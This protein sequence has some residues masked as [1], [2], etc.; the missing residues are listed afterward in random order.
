MFRYLFYFLLIK[1]SLQCAQFQG[2]SDP[3]QGKEKSNAPYSKEN[4]SKSKIFDPLVNV[5]PTPQTLNLSSQQQEKEISVNIDKKLYENFA[6]LTDY[7][8]TLSKIQAE[9]QE[10]LLGSDDP[11]NQEGANLE[12]E[13]EERSQNLIRAQKK[14]EQEFIGPQNLSLRTIHGSSGYEMHKENA[15]ITEEELKHDLRGIAAYDPSNN[16]IIITFHGSRNGA[17][18]EVNLDGILVPAKEIGLDFEGHPQMRVHRGFGIVVHRLFHS[19]CTTIEE[20]KKEIGD[21]KWERLEIYFTGHSQGAAISGLASLY[22]ANKKGKELFGED[23]NN[24]K[25]HRIKTYG[26]S[27][28]RFMEKDHIEAIE[29]EYGRHNYIRQNVHGDIVPLLGFSDIQDF[30]EKITG[31]LPLIWQQIC[32]SDNIHAANDRLQTNPGLYA[33][34]TAYMIPRL[35]DLAQKMLGPKNSENTIKSKEGSL[36]DSTRLT[37]ILR[38]ALGKMDPKT[39]QAALLKDVVSGETVRESLHKKFSGYGDIGFLAY[40][41]VQ[42]PPDFKQLSINFWTHFLPN[43]SPKDLFNLGNLK[44]KAGEAMTVS[45]SPMLAP[46][47][48]ATTDK[49]EGGAFDP[50]VVLWDDIHK[51]IPKDPNR[52]LQQGMNWQL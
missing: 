44:S 20:L 24:A 40:D 8:Y 49:L 27:M 29:T 4:N 22:F 41:Q 16:R 32:S 1:T 2:N 25:D 11:S 48:Y 14:L 34:L 26:F 19:L 5:L 50:E 18:W 7:I 13:A 23:F 21:D 12:K 35:L 3:P 47:H 37:W 42:S 46:Y 30:E 10:L 39:S 38:F 31:V 6:R 28:P 52:L 51:K 33:R 36:L 43:L 15:S 9:T 45:F 17:D